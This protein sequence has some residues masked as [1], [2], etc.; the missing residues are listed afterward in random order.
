MSFAR[1]DTNEEITE[2]L[3][4]KKLRSSFAQT[5]IQDPYNE[6]LNIRLAKS[7]DDD[8]DDFDDDEDFDDDLDDD[9]DIEEEDEEVSLDDKELE[10]KFYEED[11]D[12]DDDE[13]DLEDDLDDE[14]L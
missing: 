4:E 11:F 14:P 8:D 1:L 13:E 6:A 7:F 10:E 12:F 5:A 2:V 9:L 3:E